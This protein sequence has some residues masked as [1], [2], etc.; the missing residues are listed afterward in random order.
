MA[1]LRSMSL[2]I[3]PPLVSMPEGERGDV[4]E[5]DVLALALQHAGLQCGADGDDLIGVDALVGLLASG[6]FLD[7]LGHGGH[8]GGAADEDDVVDVGDLDAGLGDHV[9]ER[10]L[11][12]VQQVLGEVLELGAGEVLV[13]VHRSVG[14]DGEVLQGDVG[15]GGRGEFLLGL[16]GGFLQALQGDL[17]LGQ[18]G[19]LG[20]GL[21][22]QEVHD[23]LV[24]VVAAE[25]VVACGG[26]DLDGG[27][28]VL[29]LADFEQGDVEGS[30]AEVE[31]EDELVFLALV[32]AVG[33]GRGGGLVDDAQHLQAGDLAGFLGGLALGVVEVRGNGDDGVGHL[34][35]EVG[36]GVG[37]QL[38]QDAGRDL[39]GGVL[40]VVDGDGPVGAH[41]ALD[42]RDG[43]VDVVDGLALGDLADQHL[44]GLGERDDRRRGA[45][46]LG[47]RNNGGLAAFED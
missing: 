9:V 43:A 19:A 29:V 40:L 42:R 14:G 11:R 13:Q 6:E 36:L 18:V 21:G 28:L 47:V 37:L 23:A 1:V 22:E 2:V 35:A 25:A 44:T 4:D 32:Q 30:A 46:A 8:A 39:L 17:V 20:L 26:A 3:M 38:L 27:E 45:R 33:Q 15:R 5:Q 31:H 41:V 7:Q 16:L 10:L 12:A 24:P 34:L